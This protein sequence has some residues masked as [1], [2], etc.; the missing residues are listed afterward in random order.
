MGRGWFRET[1]RRV[2]RG[3]NGSGTDRKDEGV[4]RPWIRWLAGVGLAGA[5]ITGWGCGGGDVPDPGSDSAAAAEGAPEGSEAP[6]PAPAAAPAP[7]AAVAQ[8]GRQAPAAPAG[9]GEGAGQEEEAPAAGPAAG[10]AAAGTDGAAT[11][12]AGNAATAEMLAIATG[13]QSPPGSDSAP[14]GQGNPAAGP[15]APGMMAGGNPNMGPG[16]PGMAGGNPNMGPGAPGMMNPG[17]GMRP[18][19]GSSGAPYA[20]GGSQMEMM[21]RMQQQQQGQSGQQ[22]QQMAMM[23]QQ[24]RGQYAQANRGQS[25]GGPGG[26]GMMGPGGMAGRGPGMG[27]PGADNGP[28]D[29]RTPS[30]AVRAFLKALE[31]KDRDALAEAT[32]QRAAVDSPLETTSTHK[33]LFGKIL[34]GSISDSE[35]DELAKMFEGFKVAGE[36]AV[37]STGRMGVYADKPDDN[38]GRIRR[39]FT[40][41]KEKKGWGVMDYGSVIKFE[42]RGGMTRR[43]R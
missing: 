20:G 11:K 3:Q 27:G 32:A 10:P 6:A 38:G 28:A 7:P 5:C 14:G 26:P 4:M 33:D 12:S 18:N 31:A 8:A 24:M 40:V 1:I 15:G 29:T 23:Q 25:S 36:N 41:R 30:G 34:D 35:L 39:T 9:A 42:G 13:T 19:M 2:G 17:A 22:A 21:A 16:A 43:R 37:K